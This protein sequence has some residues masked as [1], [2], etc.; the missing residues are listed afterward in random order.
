MAS[1][2]RE[3]PILSPFA[4]LLRSA[5]CL[6]T[7]NVSKRVSG[8]SSRTIDIIVTKRYHAL[9]LAVTAFSASPG[10]GLSRRCRTTLPGGMS[11]DTYAPTR[12]SGLK[13]RALARLIRES[14]GAP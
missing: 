14:S 3:R 8:T 9:H 12:V 1:A 4:S 11:H 5:A 10:D 2:I 6:G 13:K 7:W